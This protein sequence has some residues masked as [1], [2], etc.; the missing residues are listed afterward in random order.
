MSELYRYTLARQRNGAWLVRFPDIPEALTEGKT[1]AQAHVAAVDALAAAIKGYRK[2]GRSLPTPKAR[3][4]YIVLTRRKRSTPG[5]S[6][7]GSKP[8]KY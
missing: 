3:A 1:L 8:L 4:A 2:A 6:G 5:P 7:T